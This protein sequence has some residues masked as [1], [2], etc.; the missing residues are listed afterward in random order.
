[1]TVLLVPHAIERL[2]REIANVSIPRRAKEHLRPGA[3]RESAVRH[4]I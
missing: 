1:M 2:L 3:C 4:R